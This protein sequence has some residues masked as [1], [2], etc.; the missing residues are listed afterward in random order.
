MYMAALQ[1]MGHNGGWPMS[2]FLTPDLRPFYGGTYFPPENRY[3][4]AG[5]PQILRKIDEI[6]RTERE[7]VLTSAGKIL[8]YLEEIS[9]ATGDADVSAREIAARCLAESGNLRS[10]H[11]GLAEHRSFPPSVFRFLAV[12]RTR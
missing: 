2:L 12:S 8:E 3:G 7:T 5:F 4:R 6:W 9:R 10:H 1:A 11:G